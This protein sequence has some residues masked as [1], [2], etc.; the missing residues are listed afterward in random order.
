MNAYTQPKSKVLRRKP[1]GIPD[2]RLSAQRLLRP[3]R[4][5]ARLG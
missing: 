4:R 2:Q 5:L 1:N 3:L